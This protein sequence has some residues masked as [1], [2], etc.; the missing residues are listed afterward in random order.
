MAGP[1]GRESL[2]N[3]AVR[4]HHE[5]GEAIAAERVIAVARE[6]S[7]PVIVPGTSRHRIQQIVLRRNVFCVID[8][9]FEVVDKEL[10]LKSH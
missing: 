2:R 7:Q 9:P 8:R 6:I 5:A 1:K 4:T 10:K 3:L